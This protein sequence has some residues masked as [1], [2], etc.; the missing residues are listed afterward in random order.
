M[1]LAQPGDSLI[2]SKTLEN[3]KGWTI[4]SR[5]PMRTMTGDVTFVVRGI[6]KPRVWRA[7]SA[8]IWR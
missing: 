4:G 1:F 5:I 8:G 2:V 6:M 7:R 3:K